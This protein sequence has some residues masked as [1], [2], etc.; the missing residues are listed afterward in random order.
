[1]TRAAFRRARRP[2]HKQQRR[3]AILDA[4]RELA[5]TSGVRNVSLGA[6]AEAVGLVKSN[7]VRYF[8]TREEIYLELAYEEWRQWAET[9]TPRLRAAVGTGEAVTVLAETITDRP[10]LCDLLGHTSTSLEH[11]VSVEAARTFKRAVITIATE[12][13]AEVAAVTDLNE[14]EGMELVA[15]AS[16]LAGDA[17]SGGQPAAHADPGLR[18]GSRAGRPLP[19]AAA[20]AR[21]RAQGSGGGPADAQGRAVHPRGRA[22]VPQR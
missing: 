15:A 19:G 17:L 22:A 9:A 6:V 13:G 18:R 7:I 20:H 10:L 2:E 21:P 8:G 12:L 1:M 11:N 16:S 3:E 4:A 5:R 14:R